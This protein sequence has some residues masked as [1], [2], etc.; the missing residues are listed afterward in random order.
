[1]IRATV[2]LNIPVRYYRPTEWGIRARLWHVQFSW[3]HL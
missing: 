2:T 3:M 1:M